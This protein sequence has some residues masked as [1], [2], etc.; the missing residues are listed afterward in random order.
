MC[1]RARTF[2]RASVRACVCVRVCACA[3]PQGKRS[4]GVCTGATMSSK[5]M[6]HVVCSSSA[7][8]P[9]EWLAPIYYR[10]QNSKDK[11]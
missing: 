11:A 1:V 2:V 7:A 10:R 4:V 3:V 6:G 8:H 5:Q 9:R